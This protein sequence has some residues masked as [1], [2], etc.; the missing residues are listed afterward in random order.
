[1]ANSLFRDVFFYD[2]AEDVFWPFEVEVFTLFY[3]YYS[4]V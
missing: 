1:M 3:F 4:R 2:F